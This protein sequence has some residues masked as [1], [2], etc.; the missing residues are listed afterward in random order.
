MDIKT[1]AELDAMTPDELKVYLKPFKLDDLRKICKDLGVKDYG[2]KETVLRRLNKQPV[3]PRTAE[4]T[5]EAIA[6][7]LEKQLLGEVVGDAE[8]EE[9][10]ELYLEVDY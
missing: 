2:T 9:N 6:I 5:D 10:F 1:D 7:A 8:A 3:T 4:D